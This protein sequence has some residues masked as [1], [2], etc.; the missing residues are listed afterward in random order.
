[1]PVYVELVGP[2]D[3]LM[4]FCEKEH[5]LLRGKAMFFSE[6]YRGVVK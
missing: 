2:R 1:M 3:E 4:A 5:E 6:V